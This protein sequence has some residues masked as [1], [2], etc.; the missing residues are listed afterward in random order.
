[1][2]YTKHNYQSGEKLYASQLNDMDD[3]IALNDERLSDIEGQG[4]ATIVDD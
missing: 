4:L 1:M 2:S 3:Q